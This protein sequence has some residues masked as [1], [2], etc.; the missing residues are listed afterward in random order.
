MFCPSCG[1]E[2]NH[3][4][5]FCRAC[6][7][8]L[9]SVRVMVKNPG[10]ITTS[11]ISS[12]EEIERA[13]ATKI[14]QT[15]DSAE[16]NKFTEKVLPKIEK[17]LESP[18]ERKL[19]RLRIGSTVSFVGLGVAIAFFIASFFGDEKVITLAAL[20]LVTLF[21]G[22]AIMVNGLL[23]TV[24]KKQLSEEQLSEFDNELKPK[25]SNKTTNELLMPPTAQHEFSSVTEHTTR[26]LKDKKPISNG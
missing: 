26:H 16:L 11:E 12:R 24:P 22:L 4:N 7:T 18:E 9:T 25:S 5:Q 23:F 17:F 13:I 19:R 6:G 15:N 1:S 14:Q 10:S 20:G 2:E 8:N 21:I 3:S